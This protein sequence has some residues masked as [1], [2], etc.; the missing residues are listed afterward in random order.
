MVAPSPSPSAR[1]VAR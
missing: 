1:R